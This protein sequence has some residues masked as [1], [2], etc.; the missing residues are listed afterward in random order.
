MRMKKEEKDREEGR[1][2]WLDF[3]E[4]KQAKICAEHIEKIINE[5]SE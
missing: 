1:G 4:K 3:V 5:Q 2:S